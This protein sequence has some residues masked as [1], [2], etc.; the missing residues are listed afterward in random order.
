MGFILVVDDHAI[1][2]ELFQEA[3]KHAGYEVAAACNGAEAIVGMESR[4][5][6][7][8]LLDVAMPVM[9]GL[10]TLRAMRQISKTKD[11]PVIM[12]SGVSDKAGILAAGKLGIKGYLLKS[13]CSVARMVDQ[14]KSVVGE[15]AAGSGNPSI[16][17]KGGRAAASGDRGADK[18]P[19]RPLQIQLATPLE[20]AHQDP[21]MSRSE[22]LEAIE[23]CGEIKG[24]SA[25]ASEV[26]K[27]TGGGRC[28]IDEVAKSISYDHAISLRILKLANSAVYSRGEFVDNV[29][30]A[31]LRIGLGQIHQAVLNLAVIDRFS[32]CG[33]EGFID[34]RRFW[35]HAV[36]TGIIAAE[37]ARVRN[38]KEADGAFTMGLLH[39]VGRLICI[40]RLGQRYVEVLQAAAAAEEPLEEVEH[41]MLGLTHAEVMERVLRRWT[42]PSQLINPIVRHH[43]P[44]GKLCSVAAGDMTQAATLV[45]ADCLA[46]AMMLGS[47]GNDAIYPTESIA[48]LLKLDPSVIARI[49]QTARNETDKIKLGLLT[50]SN[51]SAWPSMSQTHRES[52]AGPFRPIYA[53]SSPAIDA[54]RI[55][56]EQLAGSDG[57]AAPNIGVLYFQNLAERDAVS[58]RYAKAE[59]AKGVGALPLISISPGGKVM[60]EPSMLVGRSFAAMST[61]FTI[62]RF[63]KMINSLVAVRAAA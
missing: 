19:A 43:L 37:I 47:S 2:R 34:G 14:V 39:D 50:R 51:E 33:V 58:E 48:R 44:T 32:G 30:K 63:I 36:A 17:S 57:E 52:L 45:L 56:C 16:K 24:I 18:G 28:S 62:Q 54:H 15:P 40:E 10:A 31:V 35:E 26:L 27:L 29:Q 6:D 25:T 22:V 5:P 46:H 38:E 59:R 13:A 49:E 41:R 53:G 11:V 61:P 42:F 12:L 4:R 55:F 3:L 9:D 1:V 23:E 60:P 21:V 20:A 7:L 8:V